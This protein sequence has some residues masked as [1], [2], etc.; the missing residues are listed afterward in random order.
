MQ[1]WLQNDDDAPSAFEV[2]GTVLDSQTQL[3][4]VPTFVS[5]VWPA[6]NFLF[7]ILVLEYAFKCQNNFLQADFS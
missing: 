3:N 7:F 1:K 4:M 2:W 5:I 6:H